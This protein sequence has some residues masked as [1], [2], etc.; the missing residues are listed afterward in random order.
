M[1]THRHTHRFSPSVE[2]LLLAITLQTVSGWEKFA[3]PWRAIWLKRARTPS[4]WG[5][6]EQ[7]ASVSGLGGLLL[8]NS[9]LF[10]G[11]TVPVFVSISVNPTCSLS[12]SL[13][14][15]L[16]CTIAR[17]LLSVRTWWSFGVSTQWIVFLQSFI[18]ALCS[19]RWPLWY[20]RRRG[21]R[22]W[23]SRWS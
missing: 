13:R 12:F 18:S 5:G 9:T 19:M 17:T 8:L 20:E 15:L 2:S 23:G 22:G 4:V 3:E 14:S 16:G 7:N 6:G 11:M 21:R 10:P 1:H